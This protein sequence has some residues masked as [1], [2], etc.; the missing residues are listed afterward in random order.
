[1]V[2]RIEGTYGTACSMEAMLGNDMINLFNVEKA[3][4]KYQC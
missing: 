4:A 1:M 3:E 2:N